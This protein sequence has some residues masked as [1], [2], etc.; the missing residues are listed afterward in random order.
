MRA[1]EKE[2]LLG[3]D[4]GA[5]SSQAVLL[6]EDLH[7]VGRWTVRSRGNP[8][9]AARTLLLKALS[10]RREFSLR[11]GLTGCGRDAFFLG[12]EVASF[13]EIVSLAQGASLEHPRAR[14]VIEVGGHSARWVLLKG[15]GSTGAEAEILDF[16]LNDRCA[17]GSGAFLEQQ[18]A[19]LKLGIREFSELAFQAEKEAVVAGRCS[20]FAKSDMIHLQQKGT[21]VE[22]IAYGV[23]TALARNYLAT[24]LKGREC[25]PPVFMTGGSALDKG[26]VR[27]FRKMLKVSGEDMVVS[28]RPSYMG[29]LGAAVA[30][31]AFGKRRRFF[32]HQEVLALFRSRPPSREG[33]LD[34][35]GNLDAAG[36]KEPFLS[37]GERFRGYLGVDVGSVSTNLALVDTSGKVRAGIY[38]ISGAVGA[39]LMAKEVADNRGE[40]VSRTSAIRE[41]IHRPFSVSSFQCSHCANRCQVNRI[42]LGGRSIF[43]GDT[44]ER[45]TARQDTAR[46][47]A[48]DLFRERSDRLEA[49]VYQVMRRASR[50]R[51]EEPPPWGG[52]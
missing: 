29:A 44:C 34:P 30:A 22:E 35:L 14:S 50:E 23:C 41:K 45:Y 28:S 51:A 49:F 24:V 21:P 40:A 33:L 8:E 6:G 39:A 10:G 46:T 42:K 26:L 25:L 43:F 17:A 11:I 13:N 1:E 9:Q 19:R 52:G 20:V 31:R 18:A 16:G 48:L 5:V 38:P 3:L 47:R 2:L 15:D 4:I 27:A 7:P 37:E 12:E 36:R 32:G